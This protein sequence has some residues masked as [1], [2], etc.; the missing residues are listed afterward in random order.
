MRTPKWWTPVVRTHIRAQGPAKDEPALLEIQFKL[1]PDPQS[2]EWVDYFLHPQIDHWQA[3][4]RPVKVSSGMGGMGF[5]ARVNDDRLEEFVRIID[6]CVAEANAK[7]A[8]EDIPRIEFDNERAREAA[9]NE[10]ARI[11]E[12]Q[13]KLD[14][15]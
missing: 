12:A 4:H 5:I 8:R 2:E 6:R 10:R 9:D 3:F 15:L 11:E 14:S 13:R 7:Y 1:A